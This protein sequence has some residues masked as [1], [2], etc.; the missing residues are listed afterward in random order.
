M[1]RWTKAILSLAGITALA[2]AACT[3]GPVK[4]G[5]VL[6]LEGQ[7]ALYGVPIQRGIELAYEEVQQNEDRVQIELEIRDSGS[8]P[9]RGA[10]LLDELYRGGAV[11]AIGGVTTEAALLM[12][13]VAERADKVLV[14]PSA[15]SPALTGISREFFRIYP[16]D[17]REGNKM[18][19]FAAET[20]GIDRM[21]II[22]AESPYASGISDVF[23][24]EY[25]RFGGE[26]V[27]VVEYPAVGADFGAIVEQALEAHPV[28][29]YIADYA[30]NVSAII[31]ELRD[32]NFEGKILTTSAYASPEIIAAAGQKAEGVL[33][34]QTAIPEDDPTR[35]AFVKA[36][37]EKYGEEPNIWASHGY[38]SLKVLVEAI[39][40]GGRM[41]S[42][43][44]KG[45]R[46]IHGYQGATGV[47]QFDE[48]GDV[49][50]F[51]R[52]YVVDNGQLADYDRAL[53][54][55]RQEIL[56]RIEELNRSRGRAAAA[57]AEGQ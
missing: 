37:R 7:Y 20:L 33:L 31:S 2:A 10:E 54:E 3:G 55:K 17:F 40:E 15:S 42:D 24:T 11:A 35:N 47:I 39:A 16:S 14:S 50:K 12:V 8:D 34:T 4:V 56:R 38:D 9:Q 53:E 57:D 49:G 30:T 13:P 18:G 23:E 32:R 43:V 46:G 41:P 26:V 25:R 21:V 48:K 27:E 5:A 45:L 44:W 6:P 22:A 28:G 36:Y 1:S 19:N 29:I 52:T 51:P